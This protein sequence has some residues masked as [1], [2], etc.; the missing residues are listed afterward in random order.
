M[1]PQ[2]FTRSVSLPAG[3]TGLSSVLSLNG[4][5]V[6]V[7]IIVPSTWVTAD[8]ALQVSVEPPDHH[9]FDSAPSTFYDVWDETAQI[10]K[11]QVGNI[12]STARMVAITQ[13]PMVAGMH[14]KFKSVSTSDPATA[15]NQTGS[16]TLAAIFRSA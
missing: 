4:L 2:I 3:A 12:S 1:I 9:T 14:F 10:W 7:G 15:V 5:H 6:L 11:A 13:N 16:P 8:I